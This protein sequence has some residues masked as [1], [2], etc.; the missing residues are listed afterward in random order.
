MIEIQDLYYYDE[1]SETCLRWKVD[2]YSGKWKNF[3]NVGVGDI[4]GGYSSGSGYYQVRK[5]KTLKL[6][7]RIIWELHNDPIPHGMFIDHI[8]GDKLNNKLANLRMVSRSGNARNAKRRKDNTS[9]T[10][11]VHM[12]ANTNRNGSISLYWKA[13]WTEL[14]GR[15][16]SKVFNWN[17]YGGDESAKKAAISYRDEQIKLLNLQGAGYTESHGTDR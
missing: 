15:N 12:V 11:G 3:K 6:V 5:N 10:T 14:C 7:H 2:I 16:R 9:G 13:V 8:D 1:S 17:K 4:A